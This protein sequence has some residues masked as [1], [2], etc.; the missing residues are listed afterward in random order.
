MDFSGDQTI[1]LKPKSDSV[2]SA[3]SSPFAL[4]CSNFYT[5][6][7]EDSNLDYVVEVYQAGFKTF[8]YERTVSGLG[9]SGYQHFKLQKRS[10]ILYDN[11]DHIFT[12]DVLPFSALAARSEIVLRPDWENGTLENWEVS[13]NL[14]NPFVDVDKTAAS[15]EIKLLL[16]APYYPELDGPFEITFK[17]SGLK[18]HGHKDLDV[19][20]SQTFPGSHILESGTDVLDSVGTVAIASGNIYLDRV[21][22]FGKRMCYHEKFVGPVKYILDFGEDYPSGSSFRIDYRFFQKYPFYVSRFVQMRCFF[23]SEYEDLYIDKTCYLDSRNR[24]IGKVPNGMNLPKGNR[25]PFTVQYMG[26]Q[27]GMA[28]VRAYPVDRFA[29]VYPLDKAG[30]SGVFTAQTQ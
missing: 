24:I 22:N 7:H 12:L 18:M 14:R 20:Y 30:T 13:A 28:G 8:H 16:L 15:T 1:E 19:T 23:G 2:N 9:K 26:E 3:L 25:I 27:I 6:M 29:I 11:Q 17:I 21:V 4:T 10:P 5:P